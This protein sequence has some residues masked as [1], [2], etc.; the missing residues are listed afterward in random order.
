MFVIE[1]ARTQLLKAERQRFLDKEWPDVVASIK[2]LELD[3][4]ALLD[5][6]DHPDSTDE[7]A[8]PN[9]CDGQSAACRPQL[10]PRTTISRWIPNGTKISR[11]TAN[12]GIV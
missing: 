10:V 12:C 1:G 2:R 5:G 4:K 6:I 3:A 11:F 8:L 7:E 9:L